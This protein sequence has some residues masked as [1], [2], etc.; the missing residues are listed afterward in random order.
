MPNP[1]KIVIDATVIDQQG[2]GLSRY[3]VNL[4]RQIAQID[5]RNRYVVLVSETAR[6]PC[7]PRPANFSYVHVP[8][9]PMFAW[10]L[11]RLPKLLR[12]IGGDVLHVIGEIG[13]LHGPIPLLLTATELPTVRNAIQPVSGLY[14]R[15]SH[16]LFE[17]L[18]PRC[19]RRADRLT[20]I[21]EATRQDLIAAHALAP[22]RIHVTPLAADERFTPLWEPAD[23]EAARIELNAENGYIL[24]FATGDGRENSHVVL[25]AW[26]AVV[27]DPAVK[28]TLVFAGCRSDA[29]RDALL[30]VAVTIG[31]RDRVSV[32]G[33]VDDALLPRL[34]A[35]ADCYVD[36]SR[37]EGFGLQSL[38][39]MSC[40][41]PVVASDIPAISEVV[42]E[43]GILVRPNDSAS[44]SEAIHRVLRDRE[45][46]TE[47]ARR[48]VE[49]ASLFSWRET[50]ARTLKLYLE[51]A[52]AA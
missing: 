43:A 3:A 17:L 19:L 47:L 52:E 34:Y 22:E 41:V 10:R 38:E 15:A 8:A 31:I 18:F 20:S 21:S 51:L 7:L 16:K 14:Q 25:D 5:H 48:A 6:L 1:A 44:M 36:S 40:G 32:L 29:L 28:H 50:A 45:L 46:H 23:L 9:L 35:A 42:G 4:I 37:Y 49:R 11:H 30:E 27:Q 2:K 33:Y 39:A 26:R 13:P 24:G 12:R